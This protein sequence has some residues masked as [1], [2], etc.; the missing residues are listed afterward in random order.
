MSWV[1]S[2]LRRP[3]EAVS[4][5]AV[6]SGTTPG[7]P[8]SA[9]DPLRT[10]LNMCP[11]DALRSENDRVVV[12]YPRCINCLR[13]V[14]EPPSLPVE[15]GYEP[16]R[17]LTE[18]LPAAFRH[19][20]HVRVVDAGDCGACLNEIRQLTGPV[21]SLHRFGVYVTPTPRDADVLVVVGPVT[22]AMEGALMATYD[23]L[24]DPKRVLAVGACALSG[25]I[26]RGS[27]AVRDGL[28]PSLGIPVDAMVAGCPPPPL[29]ILEAL[30]VLTGQV[31]AGG[32][33]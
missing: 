19:S 26:F 3:V 25:G 6:G 13:C 9:P 2:G 30:L 17:L 16:A 31:A 23:A 24:P 28:V 11:T 4:A 5:E 33:S 14:R 15:V 1:Y 18:P 27:F 29:A 20:V 7:R 10:P 22:R 32:R 21:Y 12:D 8:V